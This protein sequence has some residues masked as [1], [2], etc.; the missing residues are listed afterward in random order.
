[1]IRIIFFSIFLANKLPLSR[2]AAKGLLL[3]PEALA[4][5]INSPYSAERQTH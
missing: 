2:S 5:R 4:F 1:M 3:S